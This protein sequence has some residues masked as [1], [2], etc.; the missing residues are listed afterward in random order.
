MSVFNLGLCLRFLRGPTQLPRCPRSPQAL[1]ALLKGGPR[2]AGSPA[3]L[4]RAPHP[5]SLH[6]SSSGL[7]TFPPASAV[8]PA[9]MLA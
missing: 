6:R 1:A 5:A 7:P 3:P 8:D 2:P 4:Q 9:V